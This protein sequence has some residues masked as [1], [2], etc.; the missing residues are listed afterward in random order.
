MAKYAA[1]KGEEHPRAIV[2]EP[3]A[4]E[5]RRNWDRFDMDEKKKLAD[6]IGVHYMT[7]RQIATGISWKHLDEPVTC[8]IP[9]RGRPRK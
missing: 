7:L 4:R 9:K 3:I 2:T 1:V 6:L 8:Y 5:V